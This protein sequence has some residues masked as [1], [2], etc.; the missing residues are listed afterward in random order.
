[1]AI[2][3]AIGE[4][5]ELVDE[6]ESPWAYCARGH[7]E[8]KKFIDSVADY[9]RCEYGDSD[10]YGDYGFAPEDVI[11]TMARNRP[12]RPEESYAYYVDFPT[13]R[14]GRGCYKLTVIE[15]Y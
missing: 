8:P 13:M 4:I 12:A 3:N 9:I 2:K 1:M 7:I 5:F 14:T 6:S 10:V 11:Q 15:L